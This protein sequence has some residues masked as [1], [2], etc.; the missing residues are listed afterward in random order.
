MA[1]VGQ[2]LALGPVRGLG[3]GPCLIGRDPGGALRLIQPHVVGHECRPLHALGEQGVLERRRRLVG[4]RR[5][6]GLILGRHRAAARPQDRQ[7][8][9]DAPLHDER[10]ANKSV[11]CADAEESLQSRH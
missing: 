10:H 6:Q 7:E 9:R 1:H 3:L 8:T 4:E 5:Q 11:R 2:E